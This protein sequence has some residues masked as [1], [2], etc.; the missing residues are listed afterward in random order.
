[1]KGVSLLLVILLFALRM[2]AQTNAIIRVALVSDNSDNEVA[3]VLDLA[4][5]KLGRDKLFELV[6]R[7]AITRV[8]RE[9]NLSFSGVIDPNSVVSVGKL[10][11]VDL[12]AVI[13]SVMQTSSTS[14]KASRMVAGLVVFD[15][16]TGARLGDETLAA[17]G[18]E[19]LSEAIAAGVRAARHKQTTVGLPTI[20][21][22][23]VRNADLPRS[24]DSMCDSVGL[25]LERRLTASPGCVVL[26]RERLDQVNKERSLP[27]SKRQYLLSSL[28]LMELECYQGPDRK[29]LI[30]SARLANNAGKSLD[31]FSVT[32]QNANADELAVV[33]YEKIA[34]AL[35]LKPGDFN[36]DRIKESDQFWQ[37]A[38]FFLSHGNLER[39]LQDLEA[40]FALNPD[41]SDLE[42]QLADTLISYAGTKTNLL[43]NLHIADRG[44]EMFEDYARKK[45]KSSKPTAVCGTYM[46]PSELEGWLRYVENLSTNAFGDPNLS[47]TE[48]AEARQFSKTIY[49]RFG[50]FR[51]EFVLP[52]LAKTVFHH[53]DDSEYEAQA[54]F[55]DYEYVLVTQLWN[56]DHVAALFPEA[57]SRHW[58]ACMK[59]YLDFLAQLPLK[60]QVAETDEIRW[61]LREMLS[62]PPIW[63]KVRPV[64]REK[65]WRLMAGHSSPLVRAAG[66]LSQL[67]ETN[68]PAWNGE[69]SP[70]VIPIYRSYL[71][72][73]LNDPAQN[74]NLLDSQLFYSIAAKN[75]TGKEMAA[76]CNFMFQRNDLHPDIVNKAGS[77][78]LSQTNRESVAQAVKL[79]N[80]AAAMLRQS[81]VRYFGGDT[82]QFTRDLAKQR[83]IAQKKISGIAEPTSP[84]L[85]SLPPAWSGVRQLVDF[86]GARKGITQIFRP[87]V[88]DD[89]VYAAGYGTNPTGG[90]HFL[91]LLRISLRD[92]S[93]ECFSKISITNI[94]PRFACIDADNYYLGTSHG[95]L[96][97]PKSSG[98]AEILDE[99]NGLPSDEVTALDVLDGKLYVGLGES[100]YMVS[101]DL[102]TRQ[103]Q[104]L[105]SARRQERLSPFDNGSPLHIKII[106]AD[107]TN[108]QIV[109]L[110]DQRGGGGDLQSFLEPAQK[111][112]AD[113]F[114]ALCAKARAGLWAFNPATH[115]FKCLQPR[116]PN[117]NYYDITWLG[118]VS[119]TQI[120]LVCWPHGIALFDFTT[121]KATI[122]CGDC[123]AVG[124][125]WGVEA[126]LKKSNMI[127][128]PA[129]H[130]PPQMVD[131][132]VVADTAS[133]MHERWIWSAGRG[134]PDNNFSRV[135]MDTGRKQNL[136]SLRAGDSKFIPGEC[137]RLIGSNLALIGDQCGLWLV[138]LSDDAA[139]TQT[140][141]H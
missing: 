128:N 13:D 53:P 95:V 3:K 61:G 23:S 6:D 4:T 63:G 30:V 54:L 42:R 27:A 35:K 19:N 2:S 17:D 5:V 96:I 69:L 58:L 110:T 115:E 141:Q 15:A 113:V 123:V 74:T 94:S 1:M 84:L 130:N 87:E 118:R 52:T 41:N 114:P 24:L 37:T 43:D 98:S 73:C 18:I 51:I 126:T 99:N 70:V 102:K 22:M 67:N 90:G 78:F 107:K 26:E 112:H 64:E 108:H 57:W 82:N 83:E 14:G 106:T 28:V 81:E 56:N 47:A 80:L 116:W 72:G 40:A 29:G 140:A 136:P 91:Q 133:F 48:L 11:A 9:Q 49:E 45:H 120:A 93:I 79:Y 131:K 65:V 124:L 134:W 55:H 117:A 59:N 76:F 31:G 105:C 36:E 38:G 139:K 137:F 88:Q 50:N 7:E 34:G 33:L 77:Y 100:G 10:L 103:S 25:L 132:M 62:W 104:A 121:Q 101:Y 86:T 68:K 127:V 125:W 85:P 92:G 39:G 71:Q 20:C 122:L 111:S 97:F 60:R 119:D 129:F 138:T 75:I 66:R 135:S 89:F 32:N 16:K 21:L 12:F 109:F 44:T 8:L 46:F